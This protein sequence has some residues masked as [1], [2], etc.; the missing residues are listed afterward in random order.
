[1]IPVSSQLWGIVSKPKVQGLTEATFPGGAPGTLR[2]SFGT[3][4]LQNAWLA[5]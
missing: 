2:N 3:F 5:S 1:V 4:W